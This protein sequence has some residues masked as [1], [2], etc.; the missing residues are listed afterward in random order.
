[1]QQQQQQQQQQ[2]SILSIFMTVQGSRALGV[3]YTNTL[4]YL[5]LACSKYTLS[6]QHIQKLFEQASY[7]QGG[8]APHPQLQQQEWLHLLT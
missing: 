1:M 4:R 2:I 5:H 7:L 8:R 6:K 3:V